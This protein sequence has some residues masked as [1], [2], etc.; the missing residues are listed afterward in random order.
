MVVAQSS[1]NYRVHAST[2][3]AGGGER[4]S[5]NFR[6][7]DDSFGHPAVGAAVGGTFRCAAGFV[8]DQVFDYSAPTTPLVL[9][10]PGADLDR[11]VDDSQL[12]ANW[13]AADPQ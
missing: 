12:C 10:G 11:T 7:H 1:E 9:D 3:S 2:F 6:S 4:A 13:S 8:N 5:A